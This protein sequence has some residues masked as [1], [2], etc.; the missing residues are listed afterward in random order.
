MSSLYRRP[1]KD[2][3]TSVETVDVWRVPPQLEEARIVKIDI[4]GGEYALLP[5]M[6]T[7]L[8]KHR[9]DLILSLRHQP[10]NART[11]SPAPSWCPVRRP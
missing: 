9:P 3:S 6:R 2:R 8:R 4:E 7:W 1:Q 11:F 5:P 10:P